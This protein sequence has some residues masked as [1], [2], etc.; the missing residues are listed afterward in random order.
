MSALSRLPP[1]ARQKIAEARQRAGDLNALAA[2]S[3]KMRDVAQSTVDRLQQERPRDEASMKKMLA[4]IEIAEA[5]AQRVRAV[6]AN[7]QGKSHEAMGLV[8]QLEAFLD[9]VPAHVGFEEV[10]R[11]AVDLRGETH[12]AAIE[13]VRQQIGVTLG[14]LA[15]ITRSPLPADELKRRAHAQIDELAKASRPTFDRRTGEVSFRPRS[16]AFAPGMSVSD[17]VG[18][19]ALLDRPRLVGLIDQQIDAANIEGL[20]DE[21]RADQAAT[22]RV[23]LFE[24]ELLEEA[25]I[26]DAAANGIDLARRSGA[27]PQAVFGVTFTNAEARAA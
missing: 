8:A 1:K 13:R 22:A 10:V 18:L 11:P 27:D 15:E 26:E 24:L 16:D 6:F 19:L 12:A 23:E 9:R 17:V 20:S 5:E 25:I 4:E 7:R 2:S 14:R 21:E 3:M